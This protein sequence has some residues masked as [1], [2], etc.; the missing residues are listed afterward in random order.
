MQYQN[1]HLRLAMADMPLFSLWP[2][3]QARIL[4]SFRPRKYQED[5]LILFCSQN[6]TM[7]F[8]C[9]FGCEGAALQNQRQ[10]KNRQNPQSCPG[11]RY[12]S[13]THSVRIRLS[14]MPQ[15]QCKGSGKWLVQLIWQLISLIYPCCK[16]TNNLLS[17]TNP[18]KNVKLCRKA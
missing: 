10:G 15:W 1:R 3:R 12:Q 16:M 7:P 9:H 13:G 14:L 18:D 5:F 17:G 11:F 6:R 2:C 8:F 4:I